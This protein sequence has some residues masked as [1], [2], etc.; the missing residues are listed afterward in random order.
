MGNGFKSGVLVGAVRVARGGAKGD[1]YVALWMW[2][3][4]AAGAMRGRCG[5]VN[6]YRVP[7]WGRRGCRYW[8]ELE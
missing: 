1:G 6:C 3:V 2:L 7:V 4:G 8:R 5:R